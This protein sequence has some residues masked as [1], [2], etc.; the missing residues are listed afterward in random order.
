LT[1]MN[2]DSL[3]ILIADDHSVVRQ[4]LRSL[5]CEEP[6]M[7]LVGEASNGLEAVALYFRLKPDVLVLDLRMPLLSG[8]DAIKQIRGRDPEAR[9]LALSS[10]SGD[11]TIHAALENGAMG[12]LLKEDSGDETVAA[13]RT[14]MGGKRW[15]PP[16]VKAKLRE[17]QR[18][19]TLSKREKEIVELLAS[20]KIN[21]EI[22]GTLGVSEETVR[23]HI[24]NIFGK[25]LVRDRTEAVMV[26]M[27][28][29]IIRADEI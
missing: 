2:R 18:G 20:G 29:G 3:R 6:D 7:T 8:T 25:L 4:G 19:E 16:Q 5:I 15:L 11:E 13:I 26:A 17:R 23:T 24:K 1:P 27:R 12:Y 21:K 28:R 22:G 9:I 14:V 10:L